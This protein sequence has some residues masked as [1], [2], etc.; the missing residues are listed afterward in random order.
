MWRSD[1]RKDKVG[2]KKQILQFKDG[3]VR[4]RE[5]SEMTSKYLDITG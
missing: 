4:Q 2:A 1:G 3:S 5:V